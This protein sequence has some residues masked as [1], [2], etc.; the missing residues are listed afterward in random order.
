ML[1]SSVRGDLGQA[2]LQFG[3]ELVRSDSER[4]SKCRQTQVDTSV[5]RRQLQRGYCAPGAGGRN[6][7]CR[8]PCLGPSFYCDCFLILTVSW[9]E[10]TLSVHK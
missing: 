1:A 4:T 5:L 8:L 7:S 10:K 3:D 9:V 6:E 2:R